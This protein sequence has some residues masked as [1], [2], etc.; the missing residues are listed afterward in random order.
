MASHGIGTDL[1]CLGPAP[2]AEQRRQADAIPELTLHSRPGRLEW[3]QSPWQELAELDAWLLTLAE[4]LRPDVIHLNHYYHGHLN[5]PAPLLITAHSCVWSWYRH[6]KGHLPD[7]DWQLYLQHVRRGL[8]SADLVT[9]PSG[10]MLADAEV[11]YGP[12]RAARVIANGRRPEDYPPAP[13]QARIVSAGRLWDEAKNAAALASIAPE[14]SWP[15]EIVGD[16]KHPDGG[17]RQY[18]NVELPGPLATEALARRFGR[19]AIYAL[20]ARYEPF[21]LSV[22][23]AALAGCA[24]VLGDIPSLREIWGDTALFVP[25]DDTRALRDTLQA[26]IDQPRLRQYY[27]TLARRRA[28]HFS[29]ARMTAGYLRAYRHLQQ[30]SGSPRDLDQ[31]GSTA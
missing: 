18:R 3:M 1:V 19:A 23:E 8:R 11:F 15:V 26:L 16:S 29:S 31:L 27:A 2:S 12:F 20:P 17:Q 24:L 4:R 22:L 10:A 13:K 14:L 28:L 25:P 30:Q 6:V 7:N 5:W 21:G 9:A